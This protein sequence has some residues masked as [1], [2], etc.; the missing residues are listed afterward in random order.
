MRQ[1]VLRPGQSP[2]ASVY[3]GDDDPSTWHFGA[4][5]N[6]ECIGIASLYTEPRPGEPPPAYRIR[7]MATAPHARGTGAGAAVLAGAL[8]HVASLGGGMV[9]CNARAP[10]IGFYQRAG[11]EIVSERF[12]IPGIGPHVVMELF[13]GR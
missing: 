1:E 13:V 11:F 5:A 10:A 2:D 6:G 3:P 8:R 9:W 12:D 7:G 4:Y